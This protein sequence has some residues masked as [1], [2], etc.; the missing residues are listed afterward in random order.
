MSESKETNGGRR[1]MEGN[2]GEEDE[3][4]EAPFLVSL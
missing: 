4:R 2:R 3:V 1:E